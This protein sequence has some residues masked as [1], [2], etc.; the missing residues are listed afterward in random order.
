M[1]KPLTFSL[2]LAVAFG[3]SSV[4]F[5]QAPSKILPTGQAPAPSAQVAPSAQEAP[6]AP[7]GNPCE[8][9]A[10]GPVKHCRLLEL[11]KH[12]PA[13]YTYEWVLKKKRVHQPLF[14]HGANECATCG[15]PTCDVCGAAMPS[16]QGPSPQGPYAAPQGP[17]AAP[18]GPYAA[19]QGSYAAPQLYGAP[20]AIA[21]PAPAATTA[22]ADKAAEPPA[23]PAETKPAEPVAPAPPAPPA[24]PAPPQA[25]AGGLL[26][27]NP[28]G[29]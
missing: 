7:C 6:C 29:Y 2:V 24:A 11:F 13:Q 14:G 1:L 15:N 23:I 25:D 8:A 26:L 18:Q 16:A 17:Y 22:P 9:P 4:S 27:L 19:A 20:Q 12:R 28:S 10:A 3:L 21:T 5:A